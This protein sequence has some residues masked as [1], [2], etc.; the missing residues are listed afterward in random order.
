MTP[1]QAF[2][3]ACA[4]D[5]AVRK[6]GNVS[7]DAPGHGM[8]AEQF[9]V[10]AE[11]AVDA[12]CEPGAGVG[13]RIEAA[14]AA[15]LAAVGCNTNLGILLLCAPI[16]RAAELAPLPL[17]EA[18]VR[19]LAGLTVDD[20]AAAYRAIAQARPGGLGA[21]PDQDVH[22]APTVDLRAA[23]AL[24]ADR[25][26][27]ARQ[28]RDGFAEL[29]EL[30]LPALPPGFSRVAAAPGGHTAPATVAAVQDLY[31][32]LLG[33]R[34]DSHIVRK[35]GETVAQNVMEAAQAWRSRRPGAP[36]L[37]ADPA[38]VAWDLDLKARG[39][40]PGTT[41][42]LTVATLMIAGLLAP[43]PA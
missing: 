39:V 15:T 10:S 20:A 38:F 6:P 36:G 37:A 32:L 24:A 19:V 40:N 1:R 29:F 26:R 14:V 31:L 25:D 43:P 16:A 3:Q 34:A 2:L 35:Q 5:V 8:Q 4:L 41:A 28:Y 12:L 7:R 17:R 21:A 18:I 22:A 42:D 11:A 30:A 13:R 9:L 23:M 33:T 27:I